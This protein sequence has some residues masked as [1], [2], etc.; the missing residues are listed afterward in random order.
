MRSTKIE[1]RFSRLGNA[2]SGLV[3]G[4]IAYVFLD[5]AFL[6]NISLDLKSTWLRV[7]FFIS[8]MAAFMTLKNAVF[9]NLIFAADSSGLKIGR[10]FLF[11]KVRQIRWS[12]LIRIEE[13]TIRI[14]VQRT[15]K[16]NLTHELP[17]V[18]LVFHSSMDL[19]RLGYKMARPDQKSSYLIAAKLFCRSLP[20]AI[21]MLREMK[22]KC[23]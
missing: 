18:K 14:L 15:H 13:A 5:A 12:E 3:F 21:A 6:G 20:D 9:P 2:I 19:G 1:I 23:A 17:A 16:P 11:N 8:G 10:G 22:E 4:C 7:F